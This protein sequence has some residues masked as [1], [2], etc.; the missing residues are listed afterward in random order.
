MPHGWWERAGPRRAASSLGGGLAGQPPSD[1]TSTPSLPYPPI[2]VFVSKHNIVML[3]SSCESQNISNCCSGR[4]V[5]PTQGKFCMN[6]VRLNKGKGKKFGAETEVL[7]SWQWVLGSCLLRLPSAARPLPVLPPGF[8]PPG[9][10]LSLRPST[11]LPLVPG[12]TLQ[13]GLCDW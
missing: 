2:I 11:P 10:L 8:P 12:G 5:F 1:L 7:V 9:S 6:L 4:R 3:V 13:V